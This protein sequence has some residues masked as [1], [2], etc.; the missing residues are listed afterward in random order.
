MVWT[1]QIG[2]SISRFVFMTYILSENGR[3]RTRGVLRIFEVCIEMTPTILL[4]LSCNGEVKKFY[5]CRH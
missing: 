2:S 5:E 3:G 4:I 1:Y